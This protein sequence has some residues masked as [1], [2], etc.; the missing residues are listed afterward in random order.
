MVSLKRV[1]LFAGGLVASVFAI[2]KF[3][4]GGVSEEEAET[5]AADLTEEERQQVAEGPEAETEQPSEE[6]SEPEEEKTT[7]S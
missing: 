3:R 2:R 1:V 4:G 7:P 5:P 6:E